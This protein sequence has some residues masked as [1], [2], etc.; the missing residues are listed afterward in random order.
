MGCLRPYEPIN[1]L[2]PVADDLWIVDGPEIRMR[3]FGLR[4]PFTTRMTIIRLSDGRLWVHSPTEPTTELRREISALGPVG[5]LVSPS[6][7]HTTWL[8]AWQ[9]HWPDAATAGV[10]TDSLGTGRA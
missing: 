1:R 10:A 4:L 9:R 2:K 8:S 5:F 7:L 3:Y 6:R